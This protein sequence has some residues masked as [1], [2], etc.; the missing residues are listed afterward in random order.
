MSEFLTTEQVA[1]ITK[2]STTTVIRKFSQLPGV[3]NLG[4]DETLH[5]RRFGVFRYPRHV[6]EKRLGHALEVSPAEAGPQRRRQKNWEMEATFELAKRMKENLPD[7]IN[8][9]THRKVVERIASNVRV[10]MLVKREEW[11]QVELP[12]ELPQIDEGDE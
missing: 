12:E 4:S 1:R 8:D 9:P 2:L 3:V 5:K 10:L 11:S 6:I 7:D